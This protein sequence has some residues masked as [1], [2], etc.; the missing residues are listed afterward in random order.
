M[1]DQQLFPPERQ[2]TWGWPAAVNFILGGAGTG[3]YLLIL[4]TGIMTEGMAAFSKTVHLDLL[5]VILIC[6]GFL[7]LTIESG[8]PGRSCYLL[9]HLRRSWISR[10]TL[11]FVVFFLAVVLNRFFP[12]MAIGVMASATAF[13]LMICQGYIVYQSRAVTA[14]N[15]SI[16]PLLFISSGFASGYG[17]VLLVT[18]LK[19]LLLDRVNILTGLICLVLNLSVW[20]IYLGW[21][22]ENA[23]QSSTKQLRRASA[24]VVTVVIG[25]LLPIFLLLLLLTDQVSKGGVNQSNIIVTATGL[26]IVA[27]VVNQKVGI[28]MK[29]GYTRGIEIKI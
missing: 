9:R 21:S 10:E 2:E 13:A 5:A 11:A 1:I 19:E 26:A 27:G 20:I 4:L 3:L 18:A 29:A 6:I 22:S 8:R 15:V 17:I 28:I 24:L 7:A 23:F 14:W 12:H 16:V 25:H